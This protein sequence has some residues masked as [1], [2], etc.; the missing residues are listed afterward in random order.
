LVQCLVVPD[1]PLSIDAYTPEISR[2]TSKLTS[3]DVR[4]QLSESYNS[5]G[6][7]SWWYSLTL[8]LGDNCLDHSLI[9]L[10]RHL[11]AS[12]ILLLI[13]TIQRLPPRSHNLQWGN[14]ENRN[15]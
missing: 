4:V 8:V 6:N 14:N 5:T 2:S 9:K 10:S 3:A 13:S 1:L 12:N 11:F 7:I 15:I